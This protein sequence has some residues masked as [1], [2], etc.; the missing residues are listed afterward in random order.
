M[1]SQPPRSAKNGAHAP[2]ASD[3][4][5]WLGFAAASW[6]TLAD[7][8]RHVAEQPWAAYVVAFGLLL[9]REVGE[10]RERREANPLGIALVAG[11]LLWQYAM[12]VAGWPR[13]ARPGLALGCL[14]LALARGHPS[15]RSACLALWLVPVPHAAIRLVGTELA[16]RL[17]SLA[18]APWTLAGAPL[19][20]D[21]LQ[22]S[23]PAGA[24]AVAA[25]DA[26]LPTAALLAGLAWLAGLRR[27]LSAGATARLVAGGALL[28]LPVQVV[29]LALASGLVAAG[30]P[31][32][33]RHLL[34]GAPWLLCAALA[35]WSERGARTP[36]PAARPAAAGAG[37]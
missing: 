22:A 28:A 9:A 30:A 2:G 32:A 25:A 18:A 23:G 26:G 34:T 37:R 20:I 8:A 7:L 24:L 3:A 31:G 11:A 35:L 21:A 10:R 6:P 4:V 33:A 19:R 5:V 16:P 1:Q 12:H 17:L 27:S 13:A 36:R 15:L 29:A 14:G